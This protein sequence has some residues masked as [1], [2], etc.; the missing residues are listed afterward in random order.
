[1]TTTYV[2]R[3][4]AETKDVC[5]VFDFETLQTRFTCGRGTALLT[6][7]AGWTEFKGAIPTPDGGS[8]LEVRAGKL[9][10]GD[11][12]FTI[13]DTGGAVTA[14]L[15]DNDATLNETK[16]FRRN[17]FEDIP[18]NEFQKSRWV[19]A[20]YGVAKRRGGG[21]RFTLR[22]IARSLSRGLFED[23]ERESYQLEQTGT[24]TDLA[25]AATTIRLEKSPKDVWREPGQAILWDEDS[26]NLEL[27]DYATIGG[28]G[29]QDLLTVTRRT[30][31]VGNATHVF[32]EEETRIF[33]A[34]SRRGHPFDIMLELATSSGDLPAGASTP[35]ERAAN[36]D[37][38]NWTADI[39]D[40]WGRLETGGTVR[41]LTDGHTGS[42][43][44]LT[45]TTAGALYVQKTTAADV[46]FGLAPAK[47]YVLAFAQRSTIGG[48][49]FNISLQNTSQ[50]EYLQP[51][52]LWDAAFAVL[53]IDK[54]TAG[55]VWNQEFLVFGIDLGFGVF[56]NYE[57]RFELESTT[58][59]AIAD[60]DGILGVPMILGPFD[61][62]P[63]G[64]FD[65]G[66]DGLGIDFTFFDLL[67]LAEIRE[68]DFQ[69][70]TFDG[71]DLLTAGTAVLF[72][73]KESIRDVKTFIE[74]HLF[75][76]YALFPSVDGQERWSAQL[77]YRVKPTSINLDD[78]WDKRAFSAS[79]WKR[80]FDDRL[81]V[82]DLKSD[83]NGAEADYEV[84]KEATQETSIERFGRSKTTPVE[85]RGHR[86]GLIGFPDYSG[87][88]ENQLDT[89]ARRILLE[90]A[91]AATELKIRSLYRFRDLKLAD[92]VRVNVPGV[93]DLRTGELGMV[94]QLFSLVRRRVDDGRGRLELTIRER[95]PVTRPALVAPSS[96]RGLAYSAATEAQRQFCALTPG[97]EPNFA[98]GDEGYTVP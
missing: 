56:D 72:V 36:K 30:F 5:V 6:L 27:V 23:F 64:P 98:N 18:E 2:E 17:G 74:K 86:T 42:A 45:R 29:D 80:N 97:S 21:Y 84:T 58:V 89:Q 96:Q 63:N 40:D 20:D 61:D 9:T 46:G 67:T 62:A 44:R 91:N 35:L 14:W 60:L 71:G 51:D 26:K 55:D 11:A 76:P 19:L 47:F 65:L 66:A 95:R 59:G 94:G 13:P 3:R 81:N 32:P 75:H 50:A 92:I 69:A 54:P 68:S 79:D 24:P 49:C 22:S 53:P 8:K 10:I 70:P 41:E 43:A 52:G 25:A 28:T 37:L 57:L 77:Y 12:G 33:Q 38:E 15:K 31:A 85:A 34:W 73:E 87:E 82:L 7:P 78:A 83:Y 93:P 88:V 4:D 1:M 39:P 90:L 16:V 48:E